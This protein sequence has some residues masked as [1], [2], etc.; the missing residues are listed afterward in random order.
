[1]CEAALALITEVGP[2][3][4]TL[5]EVARRIGVS[6]AAPY[7]HFADKRALMNALAADGSRR[8]GNSIEEALAAAGPDLRA[9]FLAASHAYVRFAIDRPAH[10]KVLF[11]SSEV[12]TTD[13][14]VVAARERTFGI[15]LRF[16]AE[17]Q[18]A[19][20]FGPGEPMEIAISIWSMHHGLA[21]LASIGTFATADADLRAVSDAA[22]ARL[23]DGLVPRPPPRAKKKKRRT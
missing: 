12:D 16:I 20:F 9:R 3:G 15:L 18:A 1:M 13:P 7:R 22:H 19:G 4:F 6:H 2:D 5:R 23:L 11:L 21:S 14:D 8:L 10:F 17:A